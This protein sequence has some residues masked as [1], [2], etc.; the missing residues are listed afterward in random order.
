MNSDPLGLGRNGKGRREKA[1]KGKEREKG[2]T[3]KGRIVHRFIALEPPRTCHEPVKKIWGGDITP[4]YIS[5]SGEGKPQ[6]RIKAQA[7]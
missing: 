4:P 1:G 2:R 6:G 5:H 3:A 7:N